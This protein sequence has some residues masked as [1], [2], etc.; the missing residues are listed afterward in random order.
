M[1]LSLSASVA[2]TLKTTV[3]TGV[4]WKH[5]ARDTLSQFNS[6]FF[7]KHLLQSALSLQKARGQEASDWSGQGEGEGQKEETHKH[8]I[9]ASTD[10]H[11]QEL[12]MGSYLV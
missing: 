12:G 8:L 5:R 2:W 10:I 11:A 9:H 7:I 1:I 6:T 4:S 3:P